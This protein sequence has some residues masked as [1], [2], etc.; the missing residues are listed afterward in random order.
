MTPPNVYGQP[1]EFHASPKNPDN[2]LWLPHS[3]GKPLICA[4]KTPP[5]GTQHVPHWI[6]EVRTVLLVPHVIDCE[7][8]LSDC[9][10]SNYR[11]RFVAA[12][13][14]SVKKYVVKLTG[15]ERRGI[16]MN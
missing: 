1:E 11:R 10:G 7:F 6:A 12:K 9:P 14:I 2:G 13:E 5:T 15:D 3:R 8:D 4:E 16:S